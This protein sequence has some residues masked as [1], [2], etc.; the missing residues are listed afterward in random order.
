MERTLR[1][2][3]KLFSRLGWGF[4][5]ML[6]TTIVLQTV[7]VILIGVFLPDFA[8]SPWYLTVISTLPTYG[9]GAPLCLLIVHGAPRV[10]VRNDR[11]PFGTL[12]VCMLICFPIMYLGNLLG[13]G[14]NSLL[15][16]VK[17]GS[18]SNPVEA[19]V[20]SQSLW[21][22]TL[23]LVL[24][25]PMVEELLC[26]KLV[27]DRLAPYGDRTAILVSALVFAL[28]H[29]NF[30]QVFYAFGMGLV[31]GY[32]YIR[33]GRIHYT[34]IMHIL[35]NFWGSVVPMLVLGGVDLEAFLSF[36]GTEDL[37]QLLPLLGQALLLLG[38]VLLLFVLVVAG[39]ALFFVF[40]K[41]I[42]LNPGEYD[43]R[44]RRFRTVILN[45]GMLVLLIL[46]LGIFAMS[47]LA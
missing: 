7:L 21:I 26:R 23:F 12:C 15:A 10:Y 40:R 19:A 29:G 22:T 31:F 14:I 8:G 42:R 28:M 6:F 38:Y 47:V 43:L 18:V 45:P 3:R 1:E 34:M 13:T 30:Q 25:A 4:A 32:V 39:I 35:I 9:V 33:S 41:R 17:G 44:G 5:A 16:L 46:T 24:L 37:E 2:D 11:L 20:S 27:I 36:S